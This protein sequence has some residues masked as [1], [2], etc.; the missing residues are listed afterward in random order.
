[1]SGCGLTEPGLAAGEDEVGGRDQA[2]GD[3]DG[4]DLGRLGAVGEAL[5]EGLEGGIAALGGEGGE[6]DHSPGSLPAPGDEALALELAAVAVEGGDAQQGGG[7]TPLH[8]AE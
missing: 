1:M 3:G 8:L 6:I 4:D 5:G 2:P 7:L